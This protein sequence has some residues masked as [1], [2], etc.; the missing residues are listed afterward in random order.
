MIV[1]YL[2][3]FEISACTSTLPINRPG[4]LFLTVPSADSTDS[5]CYTEGPCRDALRAEAHTTR[6]FRAVRGAL[7]PR[8]GDTRRCP[9]VRAGRRLGTS[10]AGLLL[11]LKAGS[12]G[13][14]SGS[15]EGRG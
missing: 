12:R 9:A 8:R 5:E 3:G 1:S 6:R 13:R 10:R 14:T 2:Q 7:V 11:D 15:L 4:A